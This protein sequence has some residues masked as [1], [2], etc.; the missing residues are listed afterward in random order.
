MLFLDFSSAFDTVNHD[1][2]LHKLEYEFHLKDLAL[3]WF[4]SF[5]TDRTFQVKIGD[6]F[7]HTKKIKYGVPQGSVL[8]PTIFSLYSQ[9][10][11]KIAIMHE[12]KIHMFADDIQI[13]T[14]CEDPQLEMTRLIKCFQEIRKWA[15]TN[16]LK[17]NDDKT[18]FLII[19]KNDTC[20]DMSPYD[21]INFTA[22][23][24]V[25][26]LGFHI[27]SKL[28]F[29]SQINNVCR[30]SFYLL[31]NL[32][33]ISSKINDLNLRTQLITSCI[34]PRIDY[35]NSLYSCLP[36]K[37]IKKL[38]RLMNAS[39]RF[40]FRIPRFDREISISEHL[41]KCHF[42]PVQQRIDFKICVFVYK[43]LNDL[44]PEYLQNLIQR[45]CSLESLRVY[46][47]RYLLERPQSEKEN[48]KNRRFSI[49]SASIWNCL[50]FEVRSSQTLSV[51]RKKLKTH[52]FQTAFSD[53]HATMSRF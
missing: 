30:N 33:N 1:I 16:G 35:C 39:V 41:K 23:K 12:C 42:L 49:C 15:K 9:D 31:R 8:G 7:S 34:I 18:K 47:D 38:Q 10:I 13:Y 28:N 46:N 20:L 27:D 32:W 11:H 50:P 24:V 14:S 52:L 25:K 22:E 36:K 53:N 43:C 19:S 51:F 48:Y 2:L 17:L 29:T 44:A 45:K 4:K 37:Q 26:N 5:L 3:S 6:S 40:I 21:N